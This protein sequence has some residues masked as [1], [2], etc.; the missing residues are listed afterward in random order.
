MKALV[1]THARR[2]RL[3]GFALCVLSLV[4]GS[5][6]A[7][8]TVGGNGTVDSCYARVSGTLRV[9]DP[10]VSQCRDGEARLAW[11]Q[12]PA[13]G[14]KGELGAAGAKGEAGPQGPQGPKGLTGD[15]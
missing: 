5:G 11:A 7:L 14:P 9:V 2:K 3:T 12:T 10:S 4:V 15:L 1:H 8:A 13:Q 6:V